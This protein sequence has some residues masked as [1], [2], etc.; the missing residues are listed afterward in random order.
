MFDFV[1]SIFLKELEIYSQD[2]VQKLNV[3]TN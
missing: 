1:F 3:L 2:R